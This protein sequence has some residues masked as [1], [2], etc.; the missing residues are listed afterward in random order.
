[1]RNYHHFVQDIITACEKIVRFVENMDF[2]QF[3]KDEKTVDA[4]IRNLEIIGEATRKIPD[5]VK[6]RYNNIDWPA[7][8]GM[9][10]IIIHEYFGVDLEEI[11]KTIKEDIPA[12]KLSVKKLLSN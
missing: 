10:N 2:E 3:S 7:I 8:I 4:V 6:E 9:R 5:S 1:M 11:W 12:L